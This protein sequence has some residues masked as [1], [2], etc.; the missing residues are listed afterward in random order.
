MFQIIEILS[1]LIYLP[2]IFSGSL[3]TL[4][5]SIAELSD[6]INISP[7]LIFEG[8]LESSHSS[9]KGKIFKFGEYGNI[10]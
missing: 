10:L 2:I 3:Q 4:L 9:Y 8:S 6:P 1:K 7:N 5:Y